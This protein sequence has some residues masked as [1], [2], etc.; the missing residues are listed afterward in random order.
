MI[1]VPRRTRIVNTYLR[2]GPAF[3]H[4]FSQNQ[5]L[6]HLWTRIQLINFHGTLEL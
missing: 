6:S 4:F 1:D 3:L 5:Y 2:Q